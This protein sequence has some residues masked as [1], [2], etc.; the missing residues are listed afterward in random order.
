MD[1]QEIA[2]APKDGTRILVWESFAVKCAY[3]ARWIGKPHN[4]WQKDSGGSV[5]KATHWMPMPQGPAGGR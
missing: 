4:V 5:A 2:T 3:P 1:W